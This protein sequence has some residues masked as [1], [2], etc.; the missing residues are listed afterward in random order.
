M[1]KHKQQNNIRSHFGSRLRQYSASDKRF[2]RCVEQ[3]QTRFELKCAR[4]LLILKSYQCTLPQQLL[5]L[6][7]ATLATPEKFQALA[8]EAKALAAEQA[9]KTDRILAS[10]R[11][12][13]PLSRT[14]MHAC[15]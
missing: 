3:S 15:M 1:H 2:E 10:I 13:N 7:M 5:Q 11:R 9:K 8:Q 14:F 12:R 4:A 6:A